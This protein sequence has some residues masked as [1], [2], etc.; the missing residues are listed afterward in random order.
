MFTITYSRY[1]HVR[2]EM[3][4]TQTPS[5][6][7]HM[8]KNAIVS[9]LAIA[10]LAIGLLAGAAVATEIGEPVLGVQEGTT[11]RLTPTVGHTSSAATSIAYDSTNQAVSAGTSSTD[12]AAVYGDELLIAAGFGENVSAMKFAVFCSGTSVAAL[13]SATET[14]RFYDL[15]NAGAYIGGFSA[16]LGA[17]PKG[18]YS[19]YT[20]TGIDGVTTI[21]MPSGDILVTQ[22]LSN[23][24]G[25][26]RMGT[27]VSY[28][29]APAV[30]STN[31]AFYQSTATAPAGWYLI[32]G[33]TYSNMQY[34][35]ETVQTVVPTESQTWGALKAEFR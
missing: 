31:A 25:A 5:G 11:I 18:S 10:T 17:L 33:Q 9:R 29:N 8:K 6:V 22:Q 7:L 28:A 19:I 26:T 13:T 15:A 35:L 24:V 16:T 20:M 27:V 30:G 1:G 4:F 23:V 2:Q 34:E 21:G 3:P 14:I 32:T 12:L